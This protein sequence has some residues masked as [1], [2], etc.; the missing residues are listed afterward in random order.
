MAHVHEPVRGEKPTLAGTWGKRVIVEL[1]CGEGAYTVGLAERFTDATL[2]GVD[3]KGARLWHGA[4]A[5]EER[6]LQ[7][8]HFLRTRIE[9]LADFFTP[10]EIDEI[11][12]TFPDP[13]PTTGN[14]KRRLT[15]PRFLEIYKKLLKP[16]GLLHLKTDN[17]AL[18]QYTCEILPG[19]GFKAAQVLRD[20]PA[21]EIQT[22]YEKKYRTEGLPI[23]YLSAVKTFSSS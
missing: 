5:A 20:A 19:E 16:G 14:A 13:H 1:G 22:P 4:K 7:N 12:I 11:W 8:A 17:E 18:F 2:V 15:A 9:D 3:I 21:D 10:E 23:H 6:G